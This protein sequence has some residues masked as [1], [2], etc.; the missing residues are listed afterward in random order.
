VAL[1]TITLT[2]HAKPYIN[3]EKKQHCFIIYTGCGGN[4]S[5]PTGTLISKNYPENYPHNA[6][7]EWLITVRQDQSVVLTFEDFEVEGG[8][9]RYDYVAVSTSSAVLAHGHTV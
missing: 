2:L 5:T 3:I 9:C 7:C 8:G 1:N 4:F 6:L